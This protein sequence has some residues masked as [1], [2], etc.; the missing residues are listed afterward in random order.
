[1]GGEVGIGSVIRVKYAYPRRFHDKSSSK[2]EILE[3]DVTCH[4]ISLLIYH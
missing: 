1:M 2:D 3:R 4:L